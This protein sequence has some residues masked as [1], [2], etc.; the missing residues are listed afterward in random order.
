MARAPEPGK[1]K[2]RLIPVL[3]RE[4]AARLHAAMVE[5]LVA[6]A[7]AARLCPIELWC[8]PGI[9]HP[10]FTR[11]GRNAALARHRQVG[12]DLGAR[13][14]FALRSAL[15]RADY[16]LLCGT[17]CPAF[18]AS[19]WADGLGALAR[20]RDAVVVPAEDGGYVAIGVRSTAE[21]LFTGLDWGGA[22]VLARSRERLRAM[23]WR[24]SEL[25]ALWDVD[26]PEDVERVS[27]MF[28]QLLV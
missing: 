20:G 11:L 6:L 28:P 15:E 26:R 14:E 7:L 16:V 24:W 12:D 17:D 13:M 5:H 21:S 22:D 27:R 9:A 23:D 18:T 4:G 3:G 2:T 8:A 25:A 10:L 19:V 1:V